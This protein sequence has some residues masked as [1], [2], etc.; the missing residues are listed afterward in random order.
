MRT[1]PGVDG[2]SSG[3][4]GIFKGVPSTVDGKVFGCCSRDDEGGIS[5][6]ASTVSSFAICFKTKFF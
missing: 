4:F 5:A 2:S 6:A 3:G 1:T